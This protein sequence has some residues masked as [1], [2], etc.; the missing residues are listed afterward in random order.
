[1]CLITNQKWPKIAWKPITTYKIVYR[2]RDCYKTLCQKA[3]IQI[4]FAIF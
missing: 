3:T 2:Y 1:M 4:G